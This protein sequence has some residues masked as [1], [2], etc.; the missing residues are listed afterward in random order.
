[1]QTKL[2]TAATVAALS[3]TF[4]GASL[5]QS[6]G[7]TGAQTESAKTGA[8]RGYG[9][10]GAMGSP[11]DA[12]ARFDTD[13]DGRISRAEAQAAQQTMQA[14]RDAARAER[15]AR[16]GTRRA[17]SGAGSPRGGKG[18]AQG[19]R[20]LD[21]VA[22]FDA[23]DR[24]RDGHLTRSELRSWFEAKAVERRAEGE[25]RFEARF[26][27]ADLNNDGRLSRVEVSEKMPRLT[28]RFAWLDENRDGFL[29]RE[30][31]RAG[32]PQR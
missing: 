29:S 23:I 17:D 16:D 2:L 11:V 12:L 13:N 27:E 6:T 9:H 24:N 20:G 18:G 10:R 8:Q 22:D 15:P 21:L 5:A 7:A 19:G 14:R 30:E 31:L 28:D 3:I 4:A 32:R 26:R 25:R 1:M